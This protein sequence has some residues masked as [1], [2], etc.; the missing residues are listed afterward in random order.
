M[1]HRFDREPLAGFVN[2]QTYLQPEGVELLSTSGTVS[3]VPYLDVKTV[4]FVRDFDLAEPGPDR[5]LFHNRPKMN[6][7]WVRMRF[8]DGDEMEGVLPNNLLQ[9]EPHGFSLMPPNPT[10]N[11]QR[12]FVPKAALCEMTVL[13]VIGSALRERKPKPQPKEQIGLFEQ[14]E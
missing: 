3:V 2:P 14:A 8:R 6:G 10:A 5:K 13:G 7:V 1:I 12:V 4:S 9:L 11:N